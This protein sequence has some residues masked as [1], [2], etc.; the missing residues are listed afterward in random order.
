MGIVILTPKQPISVGG[1]ELD[2][3]TVEQVSSTSTP[4]SYAVESGARVTDHID[5]QPDQI[6][7]NGIVTA[8][9]SD[10]RK[11]YPLRLSDM[12]QKLQ[13]LRKKGET[14][15]LFSTLG[16]Y[17]NVLITSITAKYSGAS[18]GDVITFGITVQPV[19]FA[20][21]QETDVIA[22]ATIR[23][24]RYQLDQL[25]AESK[26]QT[27]YEKTTGQAFTSI[28]EGLIAYEIR[29]KIVEN[30]SLTDE[31]RQ[32]Y[33]DQLVAQPRVARIMLNNGLYK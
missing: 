23:K 14:L 16:Y 9:P 15:E 20:T 32:G 22:T 26:L 6:S 19:I 24:L 29:T 11:Q 33:L 5:E 2:A 25:R 18:D 30:P 31:E 1:W 7:I 8:T 13:Q 12:H 21:R 28:E 10:P 3:T 27:L 4:T 17:P